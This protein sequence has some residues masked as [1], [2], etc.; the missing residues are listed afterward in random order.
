MWTHGLK[1]LGEKFFMCQPRYYNLLTE[2]K[3]NKI[4]VFEVLTFWRRTVTVNLKKFFEIQ[5]LD[6]I[7]LK[8]FA[9]SNSI[10]LVEDLRRWNIGFEIFLIDRYGGEIG[11]KNITGKY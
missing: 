1:N 6:D 4:H 11:N 8:N 10:I 7:F 3:Y 5:S 2:K 9:L